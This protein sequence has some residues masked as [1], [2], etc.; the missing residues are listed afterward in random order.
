[1]IASRPSEP[2]AARN[3]QPLEPIDT[4]PAAA[5]G[6]AWLH[7]IT[8]YQWTV[9]LVAWVGWTLDT[10]DFGLFALVLRPAL[11]DLL[12]GHPPMAEIG[13]IGGMIGAA[14]LLGWAFGGFIFGIIAD[15]IGRVRALALSILVFSVFSAC[16][17]FTQTP[18]Q[19]GLFHF[20]AGIGTG[21][22]LIVGIPLL[23]EAFEHAHRAKVAGIMMTGGGFGGVISASVYSLLGPY[24]WRYVF[25]AG[26]V[27]AVLLFFIRRSMVEPE[28]FAAVRERRRALAAAPRV[29]AEDREFLRFV[30][31]QLFSRQQRR[32]TLIGLLFGFGTLLPLWTSNIWMPTIQGVMLGKSGITGAAAITWVSRGQMLYSIGGVVGYAALGFLADLLG[33]RATI[34]LYNIGALVVGLTLYLGVTNY[35]P[36]PYLL[37]LL[38]FCLTGCMAAHAVYLPELFGTH[39]RA[40]GVAFCNGTGRV[41]TSFG[42]LAAGLLVGYLGGF[43]IA[44]GVMMGWVLLSVLAMALSRETRGTT[45]PD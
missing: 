26:I 33:R 1:M 11:T 22:E 34:V 5:G 8:R 19:L 4:S 7:E 18:L 16:Q 2:I 28:R 17:G 35:G 31:L 15:Y 3:L 6:F 14:G 41:V 36:Y 40:T 32:N 12:G 27:P 10:T 13:R 42:P 37:P 20:L 44:A 39:L 38:G 45:L 21:A 29:S 23:V 30:P 25:F 24:G 9:F 43:N